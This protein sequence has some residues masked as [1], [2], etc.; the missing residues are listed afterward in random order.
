MTASEV[1]A[2]ARGRTVVVSGL[3]SDAHTWNLIYLH[4]LIEELGY[5][6]VNLG[7]CVPVRQLVAG[8]VTHRPGLIVISS[9][10]GHGY[11]DGLSAI[12]G[13]RA[14]P[15]LAATPAVIGGKLGIGGPSSRRHVDRLLAAGF[16]AVFED[17]GGEIA[18]FRAFLAE[19]TRGADA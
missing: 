4:L 15:Q 18:S 2:S 19:I 3:A 11:Q 8:C 6:V 5:R 14:C 10:N 7:P 17:G 1:E 9:V 16:Q 12:R 13:L